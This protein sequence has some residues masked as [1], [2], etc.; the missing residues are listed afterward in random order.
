[1]NID[2]SGLIPVEDYTFTFDKSPMLK[3][4]KELDLTS[5]TNKKRGVFIVDLIAHD[6]NAR[7]KI[8]KGNLHVLNDNITGRK[9]VILDENFKLCKSERTGLYIDKKF[10]KSNDKGVI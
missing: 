3:F 4:V 1:M 2:I 5:I 10:Y 9:C 7:A 8:G 6:L